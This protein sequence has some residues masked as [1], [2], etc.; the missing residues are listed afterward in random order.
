[1]IR[2]H[3]DKFVSA[4]QRGVYCLITSKLPGTNDSCLLGFQNSYHIGYLVSLLRFQVAERNPCQ[5]MAINFLFRLCSFP[6][7]CAVAAEHRVQ[8]MVGNISQ[9]F[10]VHTQSPHNTKHLWSLMCCSESEPKVNEV[11]VRSFPRHGGT[12]VSNGSVNN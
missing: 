2:S 3:G 11:R 9:C 7:D 4:F 6:H 12:R 10:I 1:M 8:A 5:R